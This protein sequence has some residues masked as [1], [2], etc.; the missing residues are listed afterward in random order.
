M[1][2]TEELGRLAAKGR[3]CRPQQLGRNRRVA[4]RA[5]CP[6]RTFPTPRGCSWWAKE[7]SALQGACEPGQ[8][9]E[10]EKVFECC[11]CMDQT[12]PAIDAACAHHRSTVPFNPKHIPLLTPAA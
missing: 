7:V 3:R 2:F 10:R 6:R 12:K 5:V 9:R 1:M 4:G 8:S 11:P